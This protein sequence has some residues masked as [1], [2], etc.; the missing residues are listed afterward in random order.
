MNKDLEGNP[1]SGGMEK[2]GCRTADIEL[3]RS[4]SVDD[5]WQSKNLGAIS[6]CKNSSAWLGISCDMR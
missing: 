6:S 2:E 3:Y 5:Y 1:E 4:P